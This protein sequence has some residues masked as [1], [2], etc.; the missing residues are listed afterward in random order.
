VKNFLKKHLIESNK[1]FSISFLVVMVVYALVVT[2][3]WFKTFNSYWG[4]IYLLIALAAVR[5]LY[6]SHIVNKK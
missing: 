3:K 5:F 6:K 4:F 1:L 2:M